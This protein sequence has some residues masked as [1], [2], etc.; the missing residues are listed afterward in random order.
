ME[1]PDAKEPNAGD[2]NVEDPNV[3]APNAEANNAPVGGIMNRLAALTQILK[4]AGHTPDESGGGD[5][6][7]VEVDRLLTQAEMDPKQAVAQVLVARLAGDKAKRSAAEVMKSVEGL[8]GILEKLLEGRPLLCRLES[9]TGSHETEARATV[10]LGGQLRELAVHPDVDLEALGALMPWHF[11]CVHPQEMVVTGYRND[12]ALFARAQGELVEFLGWA[13]ESRYLA[14]V[15]YLGNEERIVALAPTLQGVELQAP[16]RLVLQRDDDRWAIE[17]LPQ[18]RRESRFE[19]Q[20]DTITT[21]L[22]DLAGLDSVKERLIEDLVLRV[23]HPDVPERFGVKP[24]RGLILESHKPGQGKTALIRA[25]A[26]YAR[27]LGK[28]HDFDVCL[29]FVPPGA[30]KTVW[31]GGDAKLVREDLCGAIRARQM[32]PR[33]RPLF[34]LIVLDEIDSLGKRGGEMMSSA[35]NDALTALLSEMDGLVQWENAPGQPSAEMLWVGMT[36]RIDLVDVAISRPGRFDLVLPMPEPTLESA[37]AVMAIYATCGAWYL[38][39]T[40]HTSLEEEIIRSAFL[41]PALG[42]VFDAQ[43]LRY[44]TESQSGVSVT[45]GR[46]MSSAHYE[47]AMNTAKRCAAMRDYRGVGIPAVAVEDVIEAL[48]EEAHSA[49][50]RMSADHGTLARELEVPGHITRVEMVATDE[51]RPHRY[52]RAS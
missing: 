17:V 9:V 45:A 34:Q 16:A 11:V 15:S 14:R 8:Q 22:E 35:Q 20:L 47:A 26:A 36:N 24:M 5:V 44:S 13:D 21:R 18:D 1:A 48:L 42:H 49:A 32:R 50:R 2:P 19:I 4:D 10:T 33:T 38:D 52:L 40:V 25:F 41:R 37:E 43:V 46:L 31:H 29:Y 7:L 30:L 3:E 27:D 28:E 12:P 51:P 6:P 23:L 39:E